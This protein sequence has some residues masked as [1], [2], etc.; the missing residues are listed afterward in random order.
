MTINVTIK[1]EV[2]VTVIQYQKIIFLNCFKNFITNLMYRC[3]FCSCWAGFALT[4]NFS[5]RIFV[6]S[7]GSGTLWTT[8]RPMVL[9]LHLKRTAIL[10]ARVC[11]KIKMLPAPTLHANA[12]IEL[13]NPQLSE[14]IG[15]IQG[16]NTAFRHKSKMF[17]KTCR[18]CTE[19]SLLFKSHI[20]WLQ[21][22]HRIL[23]ILSRQ[24]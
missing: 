20:S 22:H 18:W 23:Q 5:K 24:M 15:F 6:A 3:C 2:R 13:L 4:Y 1:F 9:T 21:P 7:T 10:C 19:I 16:C 8:I 14:K 11:S 12:M 17:K